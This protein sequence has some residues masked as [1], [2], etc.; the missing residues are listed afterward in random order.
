MNG[1]QQASVLPKG[2]RSQQV[3][4]CL[5]FLPQKQIKMKGQFTIVIEPQTP[6]SL[7]CLDPEERIHLLREGKWE[8]W[9]DDVALSGKAVSEERE[10]HGVPDNHQIH[11]VPSV[12]RYK[13]HR[14]HRSEGWEEGVINGWAPIFW[15][16]SCYSSTIFINCELKQHPL[17]NVLPCLC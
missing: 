11:S 12:G 5:F 6:V 3:S 1:S 7:A 14:R 4:V 8:E 17:W 10:G 9:E 2:A 16:V 13:C 15:S